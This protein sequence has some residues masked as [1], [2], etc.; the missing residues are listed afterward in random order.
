MSYQLRE[1]L[2]YCCVSQQIVF[3]DLRNDA[4]FMLAGGLER[5]FRAHVAGQRIANNDLRQLL[6]RGLLV[7]G[8]AA[9]PRTAGV[10]VPLPSRSVSEQAPL[11]CKVTLGSMIEVAGLVCAIRHRLRTRC[12]S[13]VLTEHVE[14]CRVYPDETRAGATPGSGMRHA[15]A[16][17]Q[18]QSARRYVPVDMSCLLD[19]LAMRRF[20]ARRGLA[21]NIV[22]GVNAE[23]FSA[24]AWLQAGDL[25]LNESVSYARMHTPILVL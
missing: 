16:A 24:H 22:F 1:D 15:E 19:S 8:D 9:L 25:A 3:M 20:L 7:E 12:I 14:Q 21:S 11:L 5:A 10:S 23:P 2:H 13:K 17:G 4:Y 6:E 18:Y